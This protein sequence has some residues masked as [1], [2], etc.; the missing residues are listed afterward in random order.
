MNIK[1]I[2]RVKSDIAI[3]LYDM[4]YA[5][6]NNNYRVK[7]NSGKY[8]VSHNCG[9]MDEVDFVEGANP[10][11]EQSKIFKIYK[12]VKARMKSRFL[13]GGDLKAMLFMVSS[14]KSEADFLEQYIESNKHRN[15]VLIVDQPQ[16][17]VKPHA[18]KE[19]R[20]KVAV[21]NKY[22]KSK[23]LD[24]NEDPDAYA[25]QGYRVINVPMELLNDFL[26]D[27]DGSL[28]DLAGISITSSSKYFSIQRIEKCYTDIKNPFTANILQIGIDDPLQIKDFF[29]PDIIPDEIKS[30]P[31]FIHI[32]TSLKGDITGISYVIIAGTSSVTRYSIESQQSEN[33]NLE[34][35][36]IHV[37]TVG[38]KSPSTSEISL[39]K[40]RQFIYYLKSIGFNIKVVSTDGFQSADTQQLINQ[41]GILAEYVSLDRTPNGYAAFRAAVNEQRFAMIKLPELTREL[42]DLERDNVTCKIDHPVNGSKDLSDSLAGAVYK[43]SLYK[44]DYLYQDSQFYNMIVEV[45]KDTDEFKDFEE[46]LAA[47]ISVEA[48]TNMTNSST[49]NNG[50]VNNDIDLFDFNL[51]PTILDW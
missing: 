9:M 34:L 1:S 4:I 37:F 17:E 44:S 45:N 18:F 51:D 46:T 50:L 39:E 3:P 12:S 40:T 35:N 22:L 14:K 28:M 13:I 38:I 20:F 25:R 7:T 2:E 27:I 30:R 24:D 6:P 16:W 33:N 31:G 49:T 8:I 41:Q 21:G 32:D 47:S 48:N 36:Y 11:L 15:D 43:A 5:N 10:K 19:E 29:L 42:V 23:I 26:M